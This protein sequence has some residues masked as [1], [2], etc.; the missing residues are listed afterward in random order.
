MR[1]ILF[2]I[3]AFALVVSC[4]PKANMVYMSNGSSDQDMSTA[5][6]TSLKIKDDDVLEITVSSFDEVAVK[7]FNLNTINNTNSP[8]VGA[9]VVPEASRYVVSAD[10]YINFPVLGKVFCQGMTK[11]QL[12]D[13]LE[14]RLKQYLIDP[15][16]DIKQVNLAIS[17]LGEVKMPGNKVL[18]N[19]RLNL[20]QA[21]AL[22]GDLTDAADRTK[23]KILRYSEETQTDTLV[24]LD[25][26]QSNIVN[27][28]YYYLQQNDVLYAEPD[29]NKQIAANA[30]N[31]NRN[32]L[33][34]VIAIV[35]SL[36]AI[37]IRFK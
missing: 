8:Q 20:F 18:T 35:V 7:P 6:Y 12:I 32:M 1:K 5:R 27:S 25:I 34:Q 4:K 13:D 33:F 28:P 31:P 37:L 22:A 9:A 19:E 21:L 14:S 3:L 11:Q 16:V 15:M 30:T 29:L 26:S 17:V 23:I 2:L 10:G 24:T 36:T